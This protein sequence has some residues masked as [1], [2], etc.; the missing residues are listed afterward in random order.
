MREIKFRAWDKLN[1]KMSLNLTF[2][3][4]DGKINNCYFEDSENYAIEEF[5]IMQFTGLKDKNGKEIFEG[6]ILRA[7][8]NRPSITEVVFR[9]TMFTTSFGVPLGQLNLILEVIGNKFENPELLEG[10]K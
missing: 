3:Y 4:E 8:I 9:D 5:E 2:T 1:K 10:E 7:G 6:D